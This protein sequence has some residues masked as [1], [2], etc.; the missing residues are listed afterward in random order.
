M[1]FNRRSVAALGL[2]A[3]LLA[4][5]AFA[6]QT[7][8]RTIQVAPPATVAAD[9]A[10]IADPAGVAAGAA[11]PDTHLATTD[12]VSSH[13]LAPVMVNGKGPFQFLVDTGANRSAISTS[14]AAKLNLPANGSVRVH[15]VAGQRTR[16]AVLID[17]LEV[18]DRIQTRLKA[19]TFP[20]TGMAA[21]GV[22]GVDWLKNRRLAFNFKTKRLDITGSRATETYDGTEG[23]GSA[24]VV[25]ARLRLGQITIVDADM[26]GRKISAMIDTGGQLSLGND[27]LR[28]MIRLYQEPGQTQQIELVTVSGERLTGELLYVPFIRLG[29][30]LLGNVPI[31]FATV[32]VF[33][34]WNMERDPAVI[35]G[36]DL[37]RQFDAIA[38][39]FGRARVRFDLGVV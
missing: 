6:Q 19:P 20:I 8:A 16:P 37:L 4:T 27:V 34:L 7:P 15:T 9:T 12:T 26:S 1:D 22:L 38:M 28:Q 10:T 21:D 17:Q 23:R 36:M 14:L 5:R 18:G 11:E 13:I 30:L 2:S 32:Q 33:N 35:L 31:V 25:P 24:L 3:P 29:G 39:D